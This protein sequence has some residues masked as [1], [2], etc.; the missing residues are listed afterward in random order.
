MLF[1]GGTR[2]RLGE[3]LLARRL[4]TRG[5]L[6]AALAEQRRGGGRLG[7]ILVRNGHVA[8][9]DLQ[10]SLAEQWRRL[11]AATAV[12]FAIATPGTAFGQTLTGGGTVLAVE[13]RAIAVDTQGK[14]QALRPGMALAA[15]DIVETATG[16]RVSLVLGDGTRFTVAERTALALRTASVA[17][18]RATGAR[19]LGAGKS[20][21]R[22]IAAFTAPP[23][24][25]AARHSPTI[26]IRG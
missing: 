21:F 17:P 14:R 20:V 2:L 3:I 26:G 10:R 22:A 23:V 4:I 6:D 16:A 24:D 12:G 15:G 19:L 5:Q 9:V 7:E 13:G 11:A 18:Q 25:A 1:R 8:P